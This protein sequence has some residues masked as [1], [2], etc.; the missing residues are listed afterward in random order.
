MKIDKLTDSL[1]LIRALYRPIEQNNRFKTMQSSLSLTWNNLPIST[2]LQAVSNKKIFVE[3][4]EAVHGQQQC[5]QKYFE[6]NEV[7]R[8]IIPDKWVDN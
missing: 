8:E 6:E 3:V 2:H 4:I 5:N 7:L 1:E